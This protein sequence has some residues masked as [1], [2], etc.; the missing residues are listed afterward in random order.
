MKLDKK[1]FNICAYGF[2]TLLFILIVLNCMNVK[3]RM[4]FDINFRNKVNKNSNKEGFGGLTKKK[5]QPENTIDDIITR[6]LESLNQELGNKDGINDTKKILK[7]TKKICDLE[8]AKCMMNMLN[9]SKG[10]KTIDLDSLANDEDSE[11]CIKCKK[12]TALSQ[13]LQNMIDSI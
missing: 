6:K 10:L 13:S 5:A 3:N 11:E 1:T 7:D 2:L 12:Y 4:L 8:C 9:D